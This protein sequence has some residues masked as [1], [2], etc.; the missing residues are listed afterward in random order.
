MTA[1][2]FTTELSLL[3]TKEYYAAKG[4]P[5]RIANMFERFINSAAF[6]I[7]MMAGGDSEKMSELL[8]GAESYLNE[9]A[10]SH[11][12]MASLMAKTMRSRP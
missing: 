5:E 12:P 6:T 4:D 8:A 1:P 3:T 9:A 11:A 2:D 7:A 10:A